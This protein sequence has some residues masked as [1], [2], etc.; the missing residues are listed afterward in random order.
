MAKPKG[1]TGGTTKPHGDTTTHG[2]NGGQRHRP[3]QRMGNIDASSSV[4]KA[5]DATYQA[6]QG[7]RPGNNKPNTNTTTPSN[8]T[9]T[10][11]KTT[12]AELDQP[13]NSSPRKPGDSSGQHPANQD[14]PGQ[15][16]EGNEKTEKGDTDPIDV[17]SGQVLDSA[18]DLTLPGQLPLILRRAYASG[19]DGGQFFGPGWSSTLDQ[20]IEVS[21]DAIRYF[22][23]DAQVLRYP[24]PT[25]P[26]QRVYPAHGAR[27]P[28][29]WDADGTVRIEDPHAG[30]TRHF[31]ATEESR[32]VRPI[33]AMTNRNGHRITY[34]YDESGAPVEVRHAGGYRVAVDTVQTESGTRIAGLRLLTRE[35]DSPGIT[36]LRYGYDPGG[37][38][39]EIVDS[40]GVPHRYEYDD[41]SRITAWIDRSGGRYRYEYDDAGRAI[42]GTGPNGFLSTSLHYDNRRRITTVTNS[43]GH[44]T[45]YHY[46]AHQHVV[47]IVDP[48]GHTTTMERD[49]FGRVHARTD[50][51]GNTTRYEYDDHGNVVRVILADGTT[52]T[53]D[54]NDHHQPVRVVGPD[55]AEWRYTYD[56]RGNITATTDPTGATTT[57]TYDRRGLLAGFTDALGNTTRVQS[58][59]LGL[60]ERI[61]DPAG[62]F[63]RYQRDVFG[64]ITEA[65]DATGRTTRYGWTIE[66]LPAWRE[67]PDGSRERWSYD[68]SGNAIAY[69]ST[70]GHWTTFTYTHFHLPTSRTGRDG[71]RYEFTYDS[72]LRLVSVT[73]PQGLEWRY[74]YDAADRLIAETDFNGRRVSYSPDANGNLVERVNGAGQRVR[75]QRDA[76]GRV[77]K[78]WVGDRI[79]TLTYDRAGRLV[80]AV[81][82]EARVDL[83]RDPVGRTISDSVNGHAVVSEFDAVGR[84][85]AR[86]T[87]S[88]TTSRWDYNSVGQPVSFSNHA[89]SLRFTYDSSGREITRAMGDA[90]VLTQSWDLAGRLASQTITT[91]ARSRSPMATADGRR[92]IQHRA[93]QYRP[94]GT[95][96]RIDDQLRGERT[97]SLDQV[98]RVAAVHAASWR[99]QYAYDSAGNPT[100]WHVTGS[101]ANDEN[102]GRREFT[103]TLVR[104]AGRTVYEHD[105]QGRVIRRT[106]RTLSGKEK[107]WRYV[108]DADDRLTDVTTPD[109][110]RWHYCYDPLGRRIAKQRLDEDGNPVE[111]TLFFWDGT[112]LAEQSTRNPDGSDSTRTWDYAPETFRP[113]AQ[114]DQSRADDQEAVDTAFYAIVTDLIGTPTELIDRDGQIAAA[115][116]T[117]LWGQE[118]RDD[119][120]LVDCPLRFPGQYYD[121]ETGWH[122]NYTRYYD[123]NTGHY[124]SPDPL[125][126]DAGPNQHAYVENPLAWW[127]PLGLKKSDAE[128]L[129]DAKAIHEAVK[130]G[131]SEIGARIAY[132][133]M[134]VAT[135]EFDGRYVYT[136]NQNLTSP[137]MREVAAKLGYERISGKKYTGPNQTDAEQIMLNAYDKGDLTLNNGTSGRIAPSR[138]ACGPKRQ[139][140]R[141][142]IAGYPNIT[143]IE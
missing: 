72:E 127:D 98:G 77:V 83:V 121:A 31:A 25:E 24:K 92:V 95:P 124:T 93:Y 142:R 53:T 130:V 74:E 89:G 32:R 143:L 111:E 88:G 129:A 115:P 131:K 73:N 17:V 36:I 126:L 4:S 76:F 78:R 140:C 16:S 119:H 66:G 96:L 139:D 52:A 46:D 137:A 38:L 7:G 116:T 47:K 35:P 94:D 81:G 99:E 67:E 134:T 123:A 125:G 23:D 33:S 107:T 102:D 21:D 30:L 50:A 64:R 26:G 57:Y 22:G 101:L 1:N 29:L 105:G 2:D 13:E 54:Y 106:R 86:T 42:R 44:S 138:P 113:V 90:A 20:R 110:T 141:G 135:G 75:Y 68:A 118:V 122:Y 18:E 49:R 56:E 8:T 85:I 34:L 48:L 84:R 80:H 109:G 27:W 43:L 103:G 39:S 100:S 133:G 132:N 59:A 58:D 104:R 41:A 97:Y 70:S 55:G 61:D 37:R 114:T 71:G 65:V 45:E 79:T 51:L 3:S 5:Q 136:V 60:V 11:S 120:A 128:M 10:P 112:V 6:A 9:T 91:T 12:P 69:Q 87:P 82:P 19:Y 28:L 108:W 62:G 117:A 14:G 15:K 40:S 63:L